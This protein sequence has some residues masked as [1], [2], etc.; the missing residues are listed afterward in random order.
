MDNKKN[1]LFP[2]VLFEVLN[3]KI[4]ERK[5]IGKELN[6]KIIV[7]KKNFEKAFNEILDDIEQ[8]QGITREMLIK[9]FDTIVNKMEGKEN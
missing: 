6:V 5:E 4:K 3:K 1:P 9:R 8:E 2:E 7:N